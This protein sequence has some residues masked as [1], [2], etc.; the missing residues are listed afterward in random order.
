MAT[1]ERA[2]E[3]IYTHVEGL[4]Y[5]VKIITYTYAPSP[6]DRPELDIRWGDGT[7]STLARTF[8]DDLSNEIR[9]NE[10]DGQHTYAGGGTFKISVEDPNRNFGIVNIPNSVNIPFFIETELVINPFLG[11]NNSVVLLNP[12][13][14]QGCVDKLYV[15]NP[16][17]YDPDGDSISYKLTVCRGAGGQPIPGYSLPAASNEFV[18]NEISGDM[19]WDV[20]MVQ[21]E[22]NVAFIVEEWRKGIRI[23][24]VTRDLQI[25]I[26][27][28]DNDPPV[29]TTIDDTCI[30]A[31]TVLNFD[32]QADDPDNNLVILSARGGPFLVPNFPAIMNE[33]PA[34]GNSSVSAVFNWNTK[35]SHVKLNPYNLYIKAKDST[36]LLNHISLTSYKTVS[37]QV[38]SPPTELIE[39]TPLGN[40][41]RLAWNQSECSNASGYKLYRNNTQTGFIPGHCET[42]VPPETGYQLVA[43][44]DGLETLEFL[45]NNN[46]FGLVHGVNYCYL[47]TVIFPDGAES[48][49]SNEICAYLKKDVPV[50]TNVSVE[51]TDVAS[52]EMY[53]AWSKPTELDTVAIPGPYL[54]EIYRR[55][56]V[57]TDFI[58]LAT[59]YNL[60]DTLFSDSQLNT[61][62]RQYRYRI[63]LIAGDDQTKVGST[64]V[65]PSIYLQ[66]EGTDKSINLSWNNDV[67]WQNYEHTI[68]RLNDETQ[69]FDSIATSYDNFYTDTGLINGKIYC[70]KVKTIGSYAASGL[71]DPIINFSQVNCGIPVDNVPP[72]VPEL[73]IETNCIDLKNELFWNYPDSCDAERIKFY[74]YYAGISAS[75]YTLYDSTDFITAGNTDEYRY[76]FTTAPPS[77]VGCYTV[78][79]LDSLY[80]QSTFSNVICVDINACGRI[81]FPALITPNS[82]GFNDYFS[83]DSINSIRSFRIHIFNRW[84]NVVY[85]TEDPYF[86][87]YGKDQE[88]NQ[89]CS[90][91]TYFYEGVVSEYTLNGPVERAIR[92][93]ITL[94]R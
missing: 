24:Y 73:S 63:D 81:W 71:I 87:W 39:A 89:D 13:L 47:V 94:L 30:V 51:N 16:A 18:L 3:I 86:R 50:I 72:C 20:P 59:Y 31:G 21:G 43:E 75:D 32:V 93:F 38:V 88:N 11:G 14:D 34:I 42:G 83:A 55:D 69:L 8:F 23:G 7:V 10:Y 76:T 53:V 19:I 37:I 41:I 6:A 25:Q 92:G 45:D 85:E 90:P 82:D 70:Y 62:D 84:G 44:I 17:A 5:N 1:H 78:T 40:S 46:G 33:N 27:A 65:T 67:P 56:N 66:T 35:C 36:S 9:R 12:P 57:Q 61:R 54:Y 48:Y 79:A 26:G 77:V 58:K 80:N 2:G 4:T 29:I 15:H 74:I 64:V 28:C 52:G 22:Y 49:A 68:Y 91:G 60:D